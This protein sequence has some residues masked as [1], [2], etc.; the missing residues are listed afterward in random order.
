MA[1]WVWVLQ[2]YED[3]NISVYSQRKI[4]LDVLRKQYPNMSVHNY[5]DGDF[6]MQFI[7]ENSG[8]RF[9]VDEPQYL[10]VLYKSKV[11]R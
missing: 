8:K 6:R 7:Y 1:K 4:A 9:F 3:A 5:Q 10:F 2:G 11:I